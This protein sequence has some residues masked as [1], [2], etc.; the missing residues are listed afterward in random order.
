[1]EAPERDSNA[2]G[3]GPARADY[4]RPTKTPAR[5]ASAAVLGTA[6][7]AFPAHAADGGLAPTV[8]R[9]DHLQVGASASV[10]NLRIASG[11]LVLTLKSGAAAPVKAGDE[12]VGIYFDGAGELVYTSADPVELPI[13]TFNA[14]KAT[15]LDVERGEAGAVI[16][17]TPQRI[18]WLAA[19]QEIPSLSAVSSAGAGAAPLEASFA[20]HLDRLRHV[21]GFDTALFFTQQK[22]D[23]PG[24]P[25]ALVAADGGK[26]ALLY[27]LDGLEDHS[28]SLLALRKP[29]Y[30][31]AETKNDLYKTVLSEQPVGRERRDPVTPLYLLTQV[32]LGLRASDGKDVSLSVGETVV[33][34]GSP[35][36]VFRFDLYN[37]RYYGSG[38]GSRT[39][40][41]RSVKDGEGRALAFLHR[42]DQILV[43]TAAPVP[44]DQNATLRFEIDGDFLVR[45]GGDSYWQLG[46]G[47]GAWF[48]MPDLN[49]QLFDFHCVARVKKPFLPIAS[50]RTLRRAE[51]GDEN[52][53]ETRTENPVAFPAVIAGAYQW[54]EE[55]HDGVTVRVASYAMKN[56]RAMKQLA[57]LAFG[58]IENYQSFLGPFPFPEYDIVEI[59]TWGFGQA[60]PG[61]MFITKEAF[62]PLMGETNQLFSQ[63]INERFAHEIAHQYWGQVVK[64]P[65]RDEQWLTE[66]FAEYSAAIFLKAMKGQGTY[67]T[68]LNHWRSNASDATKISPIP[69]ANRISIPSD[70]ETAFLYR[71]D[72][73]YDKGAYLLA[74]LHKELGDSMFLTFFK[75]YQKSFRW[76][77]GSTKTV[78][79]ILQWLTKKDYAPFFAE[80]YWGVGLPKD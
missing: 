26:E 34:I 37:A 15:G 21:A 78:E 67:K 77:F 49:A 58:I 10:S 43:E 79:G 73:I 61:V 38:I 28:E 46:L 42:G 27:L 60:P 68:L 45:P 48:P 75:S 53:L 9:F 39:W 57:G 3:F 30:P 32:D 80:N 20:K 25:R 76:K 7:L 69:L 1:L 16:R 17:D 71:N 11:R 31:D 74:A 41:V 44:A 56:S 13:L 24:S 14:K 23:A 18:L 12:V 4:D 64:M 36:R 51:D 8:A 70:P 66:S 35:R 62:N 33:P 50:G 47:G 22:L 40:N 72:L 63:G 54:E 5:I 29:R 19:G 52:I 2:D 55:T 6:C 59:N 65:S